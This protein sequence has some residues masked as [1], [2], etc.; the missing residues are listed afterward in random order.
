[1]I[2]NNVSF[3]NGVAKAKQEINNKLTN[4]GTTGISF[5]DAQGQK[6]F[7]MVPNFEMVKYD[8]STPWKAAL[9]YLERNYPGSKLISVGSS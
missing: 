2:K 8:P 7:K 9:K 4:S 1:M 6:Q 5:K 3:Q